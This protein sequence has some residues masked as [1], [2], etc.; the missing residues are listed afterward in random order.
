MRR[1]RLTA[2]QLPGARR[3]TERLGGQR[4]HRANINHVAGQFGIHRLAN[5]GRNFGMH[6]T[7]DHAQFHHAGHFLTETYATRAMDAAA[8]LFHRN[9]WANVL[10][11]YNVLFFG[12]ARTALTI[13]DRQILQLAFAALITD[14]AIQRM[15]NQQK[16]HHTL[17]GSD[18]HF[19]VRKHFHAIGDRCCTS[20]QRLRCFFYLN[21]THPAV[22]SD[23]Q[24]LVITEVRNVDAQLAGSIHHG[25]TV[26]YLC[27]FAVDFNF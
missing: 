2:L 6:I 4:A 23:R 20:R 13:T 1:Y 27:L 22:G 7:V 21:Q 10:M 3:I 9:E 18:G 14:R 24:L 11:E 12:V 8:H 15:V 5:K 16:L 25:R 26:S 19:G 17:L